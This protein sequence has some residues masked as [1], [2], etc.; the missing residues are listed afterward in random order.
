MVN[1]KEVKKF[2]KQGQYPRATKNYRRWRQKAP[3]LF[4]KSSFRTVPLSHTEYNGKKKGKAVVGKLKKTKKW[5]IQAILE[6][7]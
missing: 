2:R 6:E 3:S 5:G 7:R 1:K 4:I